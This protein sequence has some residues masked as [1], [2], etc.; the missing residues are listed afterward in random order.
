MNRNNGRFNLRTLEENLQNMLENVLQNYLNPSENSG[1]VQVPVQVP[2]QVPI[3]PNPS[4]SSGQGPTSGPV[5]LPNT[6]N[7]NQ[8]YAEQMAIL[9]TLR[10]ILNSYNSNMREYNTNVRDYNSNIQSS[11][12][13]LNT[14]Y[15]QTTNVDITM[16]REPARNETS[17][18]TRGESTARTGSRDIPIISTN[19][20]PI[21]SYTIFPW[22]R[23]RNT[24]SLFQNVVVRPTQE[25]IEQATERFI[26]SNESIVS[27]TQCPITMEEF[28]EGD[29]I[30]RIRHCGHAFR[31]SSITNW[32]NTNVR[33]PVCRHDIREVVTI[34]SETRTS[35]P[36]IN[37]VSENRT[38]SE[39]ANSL[40]HAYLDNSSN[41]LNVNNPLVTENHLDT[42]DSDDE[43]LDV[44]VDEIVYTY[45][46]N[47]HD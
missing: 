37:D 38:L 3:I 4:P 32:F 34:T 42:D 9:H 43:G 8:Q 28:A 14:F 36:E 24:N 26:F 31:E 45:D 2:T 47:L 16:P 20:R 41:H 1:R 17:T 29:E 44:V 13:L 25:Q 46:Y 33:C 6:N 12:Q 21:L 39:Y 7:R 15:R 30:M 23:N 10:E 19:D 40:I 27:N 22:N 35:S 5:P 11:L 18:N